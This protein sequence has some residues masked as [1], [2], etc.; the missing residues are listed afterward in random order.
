[1]AIGAQLQVG[2]TVWQATSNN[3][4]IYG[5]SISARCDL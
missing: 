3:A 1:L 5:P 2:L 4:L